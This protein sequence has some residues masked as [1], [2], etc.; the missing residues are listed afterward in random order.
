MSRE[1]VNVDPKELG[2]KAWQ[3]YRADIA[4]EGIALVKDD[5]GR[6]LAQ[7]SFDLAKIFLEERARRTPRSD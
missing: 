7:R 4:E 1:P 3:L 5:D 6:K 2:K